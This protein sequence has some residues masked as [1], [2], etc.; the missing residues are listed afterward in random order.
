MT[1]KSRLSGKNHLRQRAP[2]PKYPFT[3]GAQ[4]CRRGARRAGLERN[5]YETQSKTRGNAGGARRKSGRISVCFVSCSLKS[6]VSE[7]ICGRF[8]SFRWINLT[9][10][11]FLGS[12]GPMMEGQLHCLAAFGF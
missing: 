12:S 9:H 11:G 10:I 7:E 1:K 3:G 5:G 4:T 6:L 2:G 8:G